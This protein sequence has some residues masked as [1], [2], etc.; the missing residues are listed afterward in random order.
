[1]TTKEFRDIILFMANDWSEQTAI[2]IF[3]V[4]MGKHLFG[5][6]CSYSNPD[7][8]TIGLFYSM[9]DKNLFTLLEYI[10]LKKQ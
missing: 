9:D 7:L 5:K 8:G 6:W 10:K 4:C 3:G 2:D 1:M